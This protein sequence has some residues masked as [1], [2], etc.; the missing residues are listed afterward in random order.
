MNHPHTARHTP[1]GYDYLYTLLNVDREASVFVE[2]DMGGA[3]TAY[4]VVTSPDNSK[5]LNTRE[6]ALTYAEGA[7]K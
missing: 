2:R 5:V 1:S 3:A 6:E 4:L 7:V